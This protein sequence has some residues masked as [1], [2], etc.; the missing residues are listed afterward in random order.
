[1]NPSRQLTSALF[2]L[3]ISV[4][5]T[6]VSVSV[7]LLR[8]LLL[9]LLSRLLLLLLLLRIGS[10]GGHLVGRSAPEGLLLRSHELTICLC[11]HVDWSLHHLIEGLHVEH[12]SAST[13]MRT[14]SVRCHASLELRRHVKLLRIRVPI[15]SRGLPISAK[16]L[17]VHRSVLLQHHD[18]LLLNNHTNARVARLAQLVELGNITTISQLHDIL[19]NCQLWGFLPPFS[20]QNQVIQLQNY[21]R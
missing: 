12:R 5:F 13:H 8:L 7:P 16:L 10:L 11:H 20:V 1:M 17:L 18:L 6:L 2:D 3:V 4:R 9:L 14:I 19:L 15:F 21:D